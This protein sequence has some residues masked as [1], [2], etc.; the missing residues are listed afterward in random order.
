MER[1][2]HQAVITHR[3]ILPN[4]T[5][6]AL[7]KVRASE[8]H[9]PEA[10]SAIADRTEEW[11]S[12][13]ASDIHGVIARFDEEVHLRMLWARHGCS[14]A[15]KVKSVAWQKRIRKR[16][17]KNAEL[18]LIA[19]EDIVRDI[20]KLG[21]AAKR[22]KSPTSKARVDARRSV[23]HRMLEDALQNLQKHCE[24]L[25]EVVV[26]SDGLTEGDE[27]NGGKG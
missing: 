20:T 26:W 6:T 19:A 2:P 24:L 22:K 11:T 25:R 16:Y 12:A 5:I 8:I 13:Y 9:G 15:K 21:K 27:D 4:D 3:W 18:A 14:V 23:L 1:H 10:V 17:E 7:S